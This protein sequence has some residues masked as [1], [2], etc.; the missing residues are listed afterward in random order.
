MR[1]QIYR[2]YVQQE[3]DR[4]F[5]ESPLLAS[6]LRSFALARA[7]EYVSRGLAVRA[8][9]ISPTGREIETITRVETGEVVSS[10]HDIDFS[11]VLLN[12]ALLA[13]EAPHS[14]EPYKTLYSICLQA[15]LL[16]AFPLP[17]A[18][19]E[20]VRVSELLFDCVSKTLDTPEEVSLA[21]LLEIGLL[22]RELE[23]LLSKEEKARKSARAREILVEIQER[24][25]ELE[26]RE[27]RGSEKSHLE[28]LRRECSR[29]LRERE[30]LASEQ[31]M[32]GLLFRAGLFFEQV[33]AFLGKREEQGR[34]YVERLETLRD[35]VEIYLTRQGIPEPKR[36][37]LEQVSQKTREIL[38]EN[39]EKPLLFTSEITVEM[40]Q[41]L[42]KFCVALLSEQAPKR[43]GAYESN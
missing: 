9:I 25:R 13:I 29:L 22:G 11:F 26:K 36:E 3:Q 42:E 18:Q 15:R 28:R 2:V 41:E 33:E 35:T 37:L 39:S 40:I 14:S 30:L 32:Q 34:A 12:I 24:A 6:S 10:S 4:L 8:R 23:A 27:L 7:F 17:P 1:E 43:G 5:E 31:E 19:I 21:P 38:E 20:I 16:E